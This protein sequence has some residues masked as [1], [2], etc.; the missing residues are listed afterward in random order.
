[1]GALPDWAV[2]KEVARRSEKERRRESANKYGNESSNIN[3]NDIVYCRYRRDESDFWI[4]VKSFLQ[5]LYDLRSPKWLDPYGSD[6]KQGFSALIHKLLCEK[7]NRKE[8]KV[9]FIE[10]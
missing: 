4:G 2:V 9:Q 3:W 8:F 7:Y 1:M 10:L 6:C 5:R